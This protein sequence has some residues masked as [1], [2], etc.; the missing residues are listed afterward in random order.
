MTM[1][2]L[3]SSHRV[4]SPAVLPRARTRGVVVS[5]LLLLLGV[6]LPVMRYVPIAGVNVNLCAADAILLPVLFALRKQWLH[7]GA[8][9][10]WILALWVTNLISWWL[11]LSLLTPD[12]FLREAMKLVT[13]YLYA[14]VG[15]GIGSEARHERPF[16]K[17][18]IIAAVPVSLGA[19]SA[20]LTGLP[21]FFIVD[22]RVAGTFTDPN[23]FGIFLAM[24]A[25]LIAS[26]SVAWLLIPILV[27][28]AAVTL[29]R[30]GLVSMA[31]SLLLT[32]LRGGG[33]RFLMIAAICAVAL[34]LAWG[35]F[36]SNS[37]SRRLVE[38]ETSLGDRQELW[39]QAYESGAEHPL[40]GIGKGNWLSV[41]GRIDVAHNTFLQVI[42]D[43][44]FVGFCVFLAPLAFWLGAGLRR[45]GPRPWAVALFVGLIGG[46]AISL[47]N[48]RLF[49]L[50]AGVLVAKL[51]GEARADQA[52]LLSRSE[53]SAKTG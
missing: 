51:A 8:L 13:C 3:V 5:A 22:A 9:G 33:R 6:L 29:S 21:S 18:L 47:D 4:L 1:G 15:Y 17:G 44:G 42:A 25:A 46:L 34:T 40:F 48:F 53:D 24:L 7:S 36:T 37:L 2:T 49:W 27:A 45:P 31:A 23:A 10:R 35:S 26:A 50:V 12:V 19:V 30:T 20:Y 38:Y 14:L 39:R 16:A 43:Q 28:G 32:A 41:T 52:H 11:S